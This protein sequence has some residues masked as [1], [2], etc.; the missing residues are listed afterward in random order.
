MTNEHGWDQQPFIW[1]EGVRGGGLL[2]RAGAS[3]FSNDPAGPRPHSHDGA[4]EIM[5]VHAGSVDLQVGSTQVTANVGDFV[6]VPESTFHNLKAHPRSD[7]RLL[8]LVAPNKAEARWKFDDFGPDDYSRVPSVAPDLASLSS[9]SDLPGDEHMRS[10][11]RVISPGETGDL[12]TL[13]EWERVLFVVEGEVWVEIGKLAGLLK[14]GEFVHISG[15]MPH[16]LQNRGSSSSHVL[17]I[18]TPFPKAQGSP[19]A[20]PLAAASD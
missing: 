16:A 20:T 12:Q 19:A 10:R 17:Q 6:F 5:Y 3:W 14:V 1:T 18:D 9:E 2:W 4:S 7:L 8:V 15:E 13:R 11:L